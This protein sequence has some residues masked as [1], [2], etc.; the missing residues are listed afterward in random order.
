MQT[1]G[2]ILLHGYYVRVQAGRLTTSEPLE[3]IPQKEV[4]HLV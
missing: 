4:S 3:F 2:Q 1:Q